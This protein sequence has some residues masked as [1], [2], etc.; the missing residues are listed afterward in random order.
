MKNTF[1]THFSDIEDPRIDRCKRHQLIDI[2][3]LSVSAVLTG[4][5]G[6]EDIEQF[7]R[8]KLDWLRKYLPYE[9]GIPKHDTIARVLSRLEPELIQTRFIKWV[10]DIAKDSRVDVIAIDGKTA[11]RSFSTKERNNAL[12]MVSA[13]SCSHGLVLGQQKVDGKSNEITAIPALLELLDIEGGCITLDAMGCQ[14]DITKTITTKK[15]D[16]VIA[17]KGNQGG[18]HEEVKAYFHKVLREKCSQTVHDKDEQIDTGHG[19]IE[20]RKCLQLEVDTGWI[21]KLAGWHGLK[22]VIE[23]QSERHID[24]HVAAETRYYISS[25]EIDAKRASQVIRQHWGVENSLHWTLDMTFREDESRIRRGNGAQVM[26]ALRKVALNIVR[27]NTTRK[28]SMKQK[29]K[30][31]SLDDEFRAELLIGEN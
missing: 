23:I 7:G 29:L 10:Q 9:N 24:E 8:I 19:R 25:L 26:N 17:L 15:A 21:T 6:W 5:E 30:Q 28:A 18:L 13:W 2:L 14:K 22:T 16:Y 20:V 4:A 1:I 11:R 3:F 31:A 12:H 27:N